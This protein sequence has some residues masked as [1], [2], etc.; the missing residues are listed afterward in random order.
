MARALRTWAIKRR[1]KPGPLFAVRTSHLANKRYV[2]DNENRQREI[3]QPSS[4]ELPVTREIY[5]SCRHM[6]Q[7]NKSHLNYIH[8]F[9]FSRNMGHICHCNRQISTRLKT[10]FL[11]D[12][13]K[14][15]IIK[16]RFVKVTLFTRVSIP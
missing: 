9:G 8:Q 2:V 14:E 12:N 10:S 1:K 6:P 16:Q 4:I 3:M 11:F 7:V 15:T 5:G 13:E